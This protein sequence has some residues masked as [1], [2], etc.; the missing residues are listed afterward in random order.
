MYQF[1]LSGLKM[2]HLVAGMEATTYIT[3][4]KTLIS[5]LNIEY[6]QFVPKADLQKEKNQPKTN[7]VWKMYIYFFFFFLQTR[8][9]FSS[10]SLSHY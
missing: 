3:E 1:I 4:F 2:H 10:S 5:E 8:I 9:N 7:F 6:M